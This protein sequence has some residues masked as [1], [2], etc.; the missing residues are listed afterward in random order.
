MVTVINIEVVFFIWPCHHWIFKLEKYAEAINLQ[1]VSRFHFPNKI[2]DYYSIFFEL[3]T[4]L[5]YQIVNKTD[6][7]RIVFAQKQRK[8]W[9]KINQLYWKERCQKVLLGRRLKN[10]HCLASSISFLPSLSEIEMLIDPVPLSH[11][12]SGIGVIKAASQTGA[13][14]TGM[15]TSQVIDTIHAQFEIGR[16]ST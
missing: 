14:S 4:K 15:R 13:R 12:T 10:P 8:E 1:I 2:I 16:F 5:S 9:S 3:V 7:L 11:N 6:R